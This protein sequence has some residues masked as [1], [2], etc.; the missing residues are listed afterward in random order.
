MATNTP[1]PD[2]S[3]QTFITPMN[4]INFITR[5]FGDLQTFTTL[6]LVF[7]MEI[8]CVCAYIGLMA[9]E[10]LVPPGQYLFQYYKHMYLMYCYSY[11]YRFL[12]LQ[13]C[14]LYS[15]SDTTHIQAY[16]NI[17]KSSRFCF[18]FLSYQ[19]Y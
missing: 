6:F 10:C 18:I 17:H 13:Y 4:L 2:S 1:F 8:T 3:I 19:G 7:S 16:I 14:I 5:Q 12:Y 11:M 15:S 9:E